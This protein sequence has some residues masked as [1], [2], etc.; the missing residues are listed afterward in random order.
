MS[1]RTE[2]SGIVYEE[3]PLFPRE[4]GGKPF[5]VA[6]ISM[7]RKEGGAMVW[8]PQIFPA[9]ELTNVGQILE[10]YGGGTYEL[11][12]RGASTMHVGQPGNI[13]KKNMIT[14]PGR[15]KP[16]DPSNPTPQEEIAAGLR[17]SP[18]DAAKAASSGGLTGDSAVLIAIMQMGQQA[19]QAQAAQSQQFMALM[20]QMMQ[21][22][23][24]ESS[25]SM[26]LMM[27]MFTQMSTA[28]QQS[29]MQML[30]LLVAQKGGGPDDIEK[31]LSI[32]EK[33]RGGSNPAPK[34]DGDE[35]S[36]LDMG[37]VLSNVATIVQS[38]PAAISALKEMGP[39]GGMNGAPA[40]PGLT[41]PVEA[42]PPGSAASVL[43]KG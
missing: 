13:T 41:G 17:A 39:G 8:I 20:M 28:S 38:A 16:L 30:P 34:E 32:F 24:K 23:K 19:A 10:R 18:L 37:Q 1:K 27:S 33:L 21:E 11:W 40:I 12:A 26:R 15:P 6:F 3:H 9:N 29:L 7:A 2:T 31:Y 14:I 5:E 36:E 42:A 25:E 22:G 35:G 4:E 43:G